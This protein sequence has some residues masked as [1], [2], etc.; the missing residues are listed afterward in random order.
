MSEEDVILDALPIGQK[1]ARIFGLEGGGFTWFVGRIAQ[2]VCDDT[3]APSASVLIRYDDG[4]E[5][6]LTVRALC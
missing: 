5:E 1:V 2:H 4:D 6:T 3:D